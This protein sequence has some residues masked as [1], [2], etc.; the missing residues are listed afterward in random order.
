MQEPHVVLVKLANVGDAVA[1]GADALDAQAE[2]EAGD[3]LGIVADGR[4]ARWDRP[5][6]RR[7]SRSSAPRRASSCRLRRSAR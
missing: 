7:P 2:G 1:P 6:R 3:F 4:A 5:C